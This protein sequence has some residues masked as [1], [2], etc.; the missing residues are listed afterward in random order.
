MRRVRDDFSDRGLYQTH[1]NVIAPAGI[2]PE[3]QIQRCMTTLITLTHVLYS[4]M[5]YRYF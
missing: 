4:N 1:L 3:F 5:K 2:C